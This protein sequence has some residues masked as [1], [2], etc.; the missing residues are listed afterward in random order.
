MMIRSVNVQMEEVSACLR[1][2]SAKSQSLARYATR[3]NSSMTT[4][5]RLLDRAL[6]LSISLQ[7]IPRELKQLPSREDK[8]NVSFEDLGAKKPIS[9]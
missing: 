4:F 2:F 1:R 3:P 8:S 5:T 6:D 9:S 7:V